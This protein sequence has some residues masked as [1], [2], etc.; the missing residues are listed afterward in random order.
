MNTKR[1]LLESFSLKGFWTIDGIYEVQ[2][3]LDCKQ[4]KVILTLIEPLLK[5]PDRIFSDQVEHIPRVWGYMQ[6]GEQIL[7]MNCTYFESTSSI[8]GCSEYK[9]R[10]ESMLMSDGYSTISQSPYDLR[11]TL[12][13]IE[14]CA[15]EFQLAWLHS[16]I[17][18][19]AILGSSHPDGTESITFNLNQYDTETFT[20]GDCYTITTGKR[21]NQNHERDIFAKIITLKETDVIHIENSNVSMN[22]SD[23]LKIINRITTLIELLVDESMPLVSISFKLQINQNDTAEANYIGARYFMPQVSTNSFEPHI[24]CITLSKLNEEFQRVLNSWYTHYDKLL[25]VINDYLG[26]KRMSRY[27]ETSLLLS[28]RS[29]EIIGRDFKFT[30]EMTDQGSF[31][32]LNRTKQLFLKQYL[33]SLLVALPSVYQKRYIDPLVNNIQGSESTI[34]LFVDRLVDTRNFFAHNDSKKSYAKRFSSSHEMYAVTIS[35]RCFIKYFLYRIL[36][37]PDKLTNDNLL[38]IFRISDVMK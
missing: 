23:A 9:C 22:C 33:K 12:G 11:T 13:E 16:W 8:P 32:V 2:G 14:I 29:L 6:T 10:A 27:I 20:Y 4:G 35:L 28:I 34:D 5:E 15:I 21:V 30:N 24:S 36:T 25:L 31:E 17:G 7:L 37:I 38:S 18:R 3:Q 1:T 26:A 19:K